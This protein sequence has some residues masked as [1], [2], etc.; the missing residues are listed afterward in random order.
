MAPATM[1]PSHS[2]QWSGQGDH[3][4]LD[5][6]LYWARL[7]AGG[8]QRIAVA[9]ETRRARSCALCSERKAALESALDDPAVQFNISCF[10]TAKGRNRENKGKK[11]DD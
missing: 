4:R 2:I 3:G 5:A 7:E 11:A 9:E 6:G 8:E 1:L 10:S